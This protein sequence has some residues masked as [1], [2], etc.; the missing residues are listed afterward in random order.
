M[1]R[2]WATYLTA[3][4]A[5]ERGDFEDCDRAIEAMR[6]LAE[7]IGQPTLRYFHLFLAANRARLRGRLEEAQ[8]L[9][10]A[11]GE[12]GESEALMFSGSMMLALQIDQ[13]HLEE[14]LE[15][16]PTFAEEVP[17]FPDVPRGV[18]PG[19]VEAGRPEEAR[20]FVEEAAQDGFYH[21]PWDQA[22]TMGMSIW[23]E[24]AAH[25]GPPS[26]VEV[27]YEKLKPWAGQVAWSGISTNGSL[28]RYVGLLAA[29]MGR[30]DE[31]QEHFAAAAE[32]HERVDAPIFLARTR[33]D[34]AQSLL[35]RGGPGDAERVQEMVEQARATAREHGCVTLEARAVAALGAGA[36]T[37]GR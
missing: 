27:L 15:V 23:A 14:M 13:G 1:L 19:P 35:A 16:L 37:S 3:E 4:P 36:H 31:A 6:A 9:A 24:V 28:A 10:E 5:G 18:R 20:P 32:V 8:A 7:E 29:A 30:H 22:W 34:W 2:F 26:A 25:V 17:A 11:I 21:M 33:L 12:T